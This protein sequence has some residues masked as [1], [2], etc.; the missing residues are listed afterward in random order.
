M[1][2]GPI[3]IRL[4][5]APPPGESV[6]RVEAPRGEDIH[7]VKSNGTDKPYRYKVRSPTLG[8]L[9]ALIEMLTSKG[10]YLVHVA[11]IPVVLGGIDPCMCCMD[12]SVKF[13]DPVKGKEWSLTWEQLKLYAKR[14]WEKGEVKS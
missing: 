14:K 2:S 12:R 7:Y 5:N 1:P 4:P 11:D 6:S 13:I 8:N 9:S 10:D 3:R